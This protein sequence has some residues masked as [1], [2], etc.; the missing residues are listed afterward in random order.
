MATVERARIGGWYITA[1]GTWMVVRDGEEVLLPPREQQLV[2]LLLIEGRRPRSHIAGRLWPDVPE[3]RAASNLRSAVLSVRRR[4]PGL[5]VTDPG[6]LALAPLVRSD[7]TRLRLLLRGCGEPMT[8]VEEARYLLGVEEVLPGWDQ[9][10]VVSERV[11]AH[12]GVIDRIRQVV[13]QLI[14]E[15]EADLGL[16]LARRAIQLEPMRESGHRALATLH[17]LSGD[18]VAAWQT[19]TEFRDRSVA[20]FG[21]APSTRFEEL[22]EPLRAERRA[23]KVGGHDTVAA[24]GVRS[25]PPHSTRRPVSRVS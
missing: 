11:H 12:E 23:R 20:E 18:R 15:G 21:V 14:E 2:A 5:L 6:A 8:T 13:H 10:W 1:L 25:R 9:D 22:V 3:G 17:L 7:L 24:R 19:Y 16:R 4:A